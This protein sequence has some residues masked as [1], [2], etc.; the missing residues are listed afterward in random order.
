MIA[1]NNSASAESVQVTDIKGHE[2]EAEIQEWL[3]KGIVKGYM[4]QTFRPDN[5]ISRAEFVALVNR[6]FRYMNQEKV[7]FKDLKPTDWE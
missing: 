3:D 7:D 6:A 1:S 2:A 4:D 5:E